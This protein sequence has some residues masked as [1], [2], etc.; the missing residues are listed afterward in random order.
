MVCEDIYL[1][2]EIPHTEILGVAQKNAIANLTTFAKGNLRI[3]KLYL[4]GVL[5]CSSLMANLISEPTL[6]QAGCTITSRNG[7]KTIS[8]DG[9]IILTAELRNRL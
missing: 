2:D 5:K 8:K 1:E 9:Q 3:G 4:T 7:I 6:D